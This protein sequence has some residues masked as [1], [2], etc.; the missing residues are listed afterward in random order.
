MNR[1]CRSFAAVSMLGI[2]FFTVPVQAYEKVSSNSNSLCLTE[3]V[4]DISAEEY[5]QAKSQ[6]ADVDYETLISNTV[7]SQTSAERHYRKYSRTYQYPENPEYQAVLT[8]YFMIEGQGNC[9][10]IVEVGAVT[11]DLSPDSVNCEW[12]GNAG[13]SSNVSAHDCTIIG[14][15]QFRDTYK[16]KIP[17]SRLFIIGKNYYTYSSQFTMRR[18]ITVDMLR[19]HTLRR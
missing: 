18:D 13:Y 17:I 1:F 4:T 8:G 11:T 5:C 19:P 6:A 7:P 14:G 9:Y 10:D 15:G 12:L 2:L 16:L 3:C